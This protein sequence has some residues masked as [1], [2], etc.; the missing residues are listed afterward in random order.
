MMEEV[1]VAHLLNYAPLSALVGIRVNWNVRPQIS[2]LP[3]V[4][5]TKVSAERS[6]HMLGSNGL[7]AARIQMDCWGFTFASVMSVARALRDV[8]SGAKF[9]EDGVQFQGIFL[10]AER[11]FFEEEAAERFHRVS[12]DFIIWHSE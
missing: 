8:L 12:L 3:S 4:V 11:H 7:V 1:L 10:D 9:T 6:Y 2:E 5:M